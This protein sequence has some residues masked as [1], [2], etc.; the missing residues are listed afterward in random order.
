M[1]LSNEISNRSKLIR[2]ILENVALDK[3]DSSSTS[4]SKST[5]NFK[6]KCKQ[7]FNVM[8]KSNLNQHPTDQADLV[9]M[10]TNKPRNK[11]TKSNS[12]YNYS[13]YRPYRSK[14]QLKFHKNSLN[15]TD[16]SSRINTSV[17][18]KVIDLVTLPNRTN[19]STTRKQERQLLQISNVRKHKQFTIRCLL[20]FLMNLLIVLQFFDKTNADTCLEHCTCIYSKNKFIADCSALALDSLPVVSIKI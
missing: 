10:L 2:K 1:I 7:K 11:L 20:P 8:N 6:A 17:K 15:K 13:F 3:A 12:A 5:K 4:K 16:K 14:N 18:T 9:E 19:E